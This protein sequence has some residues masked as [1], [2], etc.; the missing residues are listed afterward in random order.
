MQIRNKNMLSVGL[1]S[2]VLSI[3]IG[4]FTSLIYNG[5][6]VSDF[7]AGF[8]IGLSIVM[9]LAYAIRL[10]TKTIPLNSAL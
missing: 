8:F 9:M 4:K 6:M 1:L 10:R 3:L 5:I 7:L 2:L